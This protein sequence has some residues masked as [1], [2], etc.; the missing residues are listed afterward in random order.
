MEPPLANNVLP[1]PFR[2]FNLSHLPFEYAHKVLKMDR[3]EL[4][5]RFSA[6]QCATCVR[7][8][9]LFLDPTEPNRRSIVCHEKCTWKKC[10]GL[11]EFPVEKQRQYLS[12]CATALNT[13][14]RPTRV[15]HCLHVL[16]S[17]DADDFP[18]LSNLHASLPVQLVTSKLASM[19]H[20]VLSHMRT[21]HGD[22]A[23]HS[24]HETALHS[25]TCVEVEPEDIRV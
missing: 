20:P 25:H 10:P 16:P 24:L 12:E 6:K 8:T 4:D 23:F 14:T 9:Q 22:T 3:A 13:R 19:T 15:R 5:R 7:P 21:S 11:K 18:T 17:V 2:Q 1:Q